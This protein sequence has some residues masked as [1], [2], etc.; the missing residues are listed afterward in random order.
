M[1]FVKCYSKLKHDVFLI[2]CIKLQ[3]RGV[4]GAS[5]H[6]LGFSGQNNLI[7]LFSKITPPIIKIDFVAKFLRLFNNWFNEETL[8]LG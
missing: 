6:I 4:G 5:Y 1:R 3:N 8:S 7:E 2:F